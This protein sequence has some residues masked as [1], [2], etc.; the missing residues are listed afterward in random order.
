[1]NEPPDEV[2]AVDG[3]PP[4]VVVDNVVTVGAAL[5]V[6]GAPAIGAVGPAAGG[7]GIHV[8]VTAPEVHVVVPAGGPESLIGVV[9]ALTLVVTG[10]ALLVVGGAEIPLVVTTVVVVVV[11]VSSIEV[12]V[13]R[14]TWLYDCAVAVTLVPEVVLGL[15]TNA[16]PP[17]PR[18]WHD[19][20]LLVAL[21][22]H[23][24]WPPT[25]VLQP[26]PPVLAGVPPFR[27]RHENA[28]EPPG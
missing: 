22:T 23:H 28:S 6:T 3:V 26:T 15:Q 21:N 10:A 12:T 19:V 20:P 9:A 11:D 18:V 13:F 25:S 24:C 7:V 14:M 1:M 8:T 4:E 16:L 5:V 27:V 17:A 2:V